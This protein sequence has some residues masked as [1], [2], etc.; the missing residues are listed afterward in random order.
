MATFFGEIVE[1]ASRACFDFEEDNFEDEQLLEKCELCI[2]WKTEIPKNI[3]L[4]LICQ[5]P[6]SKAF[7]EHYFIDEGKC[8]GQVEK[9]QRSV[10]KEAA[11]F[12]SLSNDTLVCVAT[13]VDDTLSTLFVDLVAS[14]V[15]LAARVIIICSRPAS[16]FFGE[17]KNE[18]GTLR[19]LAVAGKTDDYGIK[20]STLEQPN[21]VSGVSAAVLSYCC[22]KKKSA[23]LFVCFSEDISAVIDSRT[24]TPLDPILMSPLLQPLL[25]GNRQSKVSG[26]STGNIYM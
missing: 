11:K 4:L 25:K 6:I 16:Q 5:G 8:C 22:L 26:I 12:Y 9:S 20:C 21:F 14:V 7:A 2:S 13:G 15:D 19:C 18:E 24:L 1:P 23:C 10:K 17:S 3:K